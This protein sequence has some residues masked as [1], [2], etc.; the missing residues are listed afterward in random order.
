MA[1]FDVAWGYDIYQNA[2]KNG[3]GQK[4]NL[5]ETPAL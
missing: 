5:W 1:V 2:L 4:L 3:I